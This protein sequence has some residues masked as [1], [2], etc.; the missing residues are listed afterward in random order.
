MT[1]EMHAGGPS[2]Q[3]TVSSPDAVGPCRSPEVIAL[4]HPIGHPDIVSLEATAFFPILR[5]GKKPGDQHW[6]DLMR[7]PTSP[8]L[9]IG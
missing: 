9:E 4:C 5:T 3:G 7:L 1:T 6:I 2:T 8:A